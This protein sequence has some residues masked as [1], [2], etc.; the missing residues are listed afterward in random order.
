[1]RTYSPWNNYDPVDWWLDRMFGFEF[2]RDQLDPDA[3]T[4]E[5]HEAMTRD[6]IRYGYIWGSH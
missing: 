6:V 4:P 1:M 2:I 3:W 5:F